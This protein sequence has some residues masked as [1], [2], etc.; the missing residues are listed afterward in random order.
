M[1]EIE[2]DRGKQQRKRYGECH[3]QRTAHVAQEK[4]QDDRYQHHAIC[5]VSKHGMRGVLDEIA[6]VKMGN[7]PYSVGEKTVIQV[8]DF[9]VKSLKRCVGFR[10]LSQQDDAFTTVA[11]MSPVFV[12]SPTA[13]TFSACSPRSM[14]PPPALMLLL[15]RACSIWVSES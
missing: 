10:A 1:A 7:N 2:Q 15:A 6:T 12:I 3:N 5:E 11:P 4:E 9:L 8:V 14:K 13:R